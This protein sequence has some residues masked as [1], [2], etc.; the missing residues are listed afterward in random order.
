[1][2]A[3][4]AMAKKRFIGPVP[5]PANFELSAR[6]RLLAR[7]KALLIPAKRPLHSTERNQVGQLV[8]PPGAV[9]ATE[10]A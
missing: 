2:K 7:A 1:M 5:F 9:F 6:V 3:A 4:A 8:G 10:G